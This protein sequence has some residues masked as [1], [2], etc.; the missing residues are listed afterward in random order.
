MNGNYAE[1]FGKFLIFPE[2][3]IIS[4]LRID[5]LFFIE[6]NHFQIVSNTFGYNPHGVDINKNKLKLVIGVRYL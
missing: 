6:Y 1:G 2:I 3:Y 5:I 4:N